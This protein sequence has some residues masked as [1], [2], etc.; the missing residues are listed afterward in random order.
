VFEGEAG[1]AGQDVDPVR[2]QAELRDDIGFDEIR[3]GDVES[4]ASMSW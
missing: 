4:A 1:N 3:L 2:W